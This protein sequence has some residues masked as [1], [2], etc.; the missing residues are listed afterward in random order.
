MATRGRGSKSK[1]S[2]FERQIAK[3]LS[4]YFFGVDDRLKRTP[5]SGGFSKS[6]KGDIFE[7][8]SVKISDD[9]VISNTPQWPFSVECKKQEVPLDI[10]SLLSD[11]SVFWKFWDQCS[12]QIKGTPEAGKIPMLIFSK[13]NIKP[14]VCLPAEILMSISLVPKNFIETKNVVIFKLEDFLKIPPEQFKLIDL[15]KYEIKSLD[16]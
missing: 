6:Y 14:M 1:G 12:S 13:N 5:L 4:R 9:P 11:N 10:P 3:T 16:E 2:N 7:D 15:S 8:L